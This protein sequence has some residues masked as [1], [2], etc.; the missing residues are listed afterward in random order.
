MQ[1]C[2]AD[3]FEV[4]VTDDGSHD[5]SEEVVA[6]FAQSVDFSVAFTT[7]PHNGFQLAKC[8]NEGV[9]ASRAPYIIFL[10]GDLI[11]PNDFV[12]KHLHN[13]RRQIAMVGDSIW[14]NQQVSES[15]GV[16]EI[17]QGD[18]RAWAT[19]EEE[20]RMRWK[21]LRASIYSRLG[22]PDRPRMK[23]GNIALWRSDYETINGYDQD[24]VGWGL[25]DSDL[26]RR[27]YQA[28]VRFRSSMRWTRT[29]HMWHARDPSY[30]A[31][32]SGTDNEKL[33]RANR[34]TRC[35]NGL[36][37]RHDMKV[38]YFDGPSAARRAA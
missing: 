5:Q 26:Q 24:F 34:P 37:Q 36:N 4:I 23:G 31:K 17:R 7:H 27:L 11:C 35:A 32:A 28:G 25:E 20:R 10:D 30:V 22:L 13:R 3:L 15:I 12:A 8:R 2:G 1:R 16:D 29:H 6:R 21:A 33:M 9:A 38:R 18:F 19:E 14:M